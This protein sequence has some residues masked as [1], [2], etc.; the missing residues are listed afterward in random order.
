[1]SKFWK[2]LLFILT[3]LG[4]ALV[5]STSLRKKQT[6][7]IDEIDAVEAIHSPEIERLQTQLVLLNSDVEA[8]KTAVAEA[9]RSLAQSRE[10]LR[11]VY[12]TGGLKAAE[13]ASR[14]R[15]LKL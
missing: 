1:M 14:F 7:R 4:G 2:W 10:E 8:D 3:V 13:Q 15:K 9:E 5:A 12:Q 11:K 6:P